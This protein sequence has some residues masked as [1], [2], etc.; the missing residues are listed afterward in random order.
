VQTL[1]EVVAGIGPFAVAGRFSAPSLD[2]KN[3]ACLAAAGSGDHCA[4]GETCGRRTSSAMAYT[5]RGGWIRARPTWQGRR[6]APAAATARSAV[7][8]NRHRAWP[9]PAPPTRYRRPACSP[10]DGAPCQTPQHRQ[11]ARG[12]RD[13]HHSCDF[14]D[15]VDDGRPIRSAIDRAVRPAAI[16]REI[17]S[18]SIRVR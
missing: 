18:R 6:D 8:T 12:T 11:P 15:T 17:S 3:S 1:R 10:S 5:H 7:V 13:D 4:H 9:R 2:V 14:L 16:L